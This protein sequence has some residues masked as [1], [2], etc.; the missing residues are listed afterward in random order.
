MS[1]PSSSKRPALRYLRAAV[2][3]ARDDAGPRVLAT[4]CLESLDL[5]LVALHGGSG[6]THT[7]SPPMILRVAGSHLRFLSLSEDS[8]G[9]PVGTLVAHCPALAGLSISELP[10][11][12]TLTLPDAAP[13]R[14]RSLRVDRCPALAPACLLACLGQHGA[15]LHPLRR[16]E[17]SNDPTTEDLA[18][19][20]TRARQTTLRS[21]MLDCPLLEELRAPL[22]SEMQRFELVGLAINLRLIACVSPQ[23]KQRLEGRWPGVTFIEPLM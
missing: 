12:A 19:L 4:D 13:A 18:P 21:L 11:L 23:W 1:S 10:D 14:L 2:A 9:A 17:L 22:G 3:V 15:G 6:P 5:A 20:G 8:P 16:L 7:R